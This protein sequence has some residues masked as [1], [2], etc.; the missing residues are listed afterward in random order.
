MRL[1]RL[2]TVPKT[3]VRDLPRTNGWKLPH[4]PPNSKWRPSGNTGEI[5]AARKGT[6]HPTSQSLWP[7]TSVLSDRQSPTYEPCMGL[8]FTFTINFI[9]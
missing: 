6:G 2:P 4:C 3:R 8:T 1:D 9:T 5:K 7:R